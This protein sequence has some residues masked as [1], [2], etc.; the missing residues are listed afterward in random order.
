M[1]LCWN[2]IFKK[3]IIKHF[4]KQRL[5]LALKLDII[6]FPLQFLIS[7]LGTMEGEGGGSEPTLWNENLS[8][9]VF[10]HYECV[11]SNWPLRTHDLSLINTNGD[12][13]K[14]I[15][16]KFIRLFDTMIPRLV[17]ALETCDG[18]EVAPPVYPAFLLADVAVASPLQVH[19][20]RQEVVSDEKISRLRFTNS[21]CTTRRF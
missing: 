18:V 10:F 21:G 13:T 3:L 15:I 17:L 9:W 8:V 11:V 19:L 2:A 20:K 14:T 7:T 6:Q 16:Y 1:I 4:I 5:S 12:T